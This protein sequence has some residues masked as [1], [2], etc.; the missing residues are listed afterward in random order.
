MFFYLRKQEAGIRAEQIESI[1]RVQLEKAELQ[2]ELTRQDT[3]IAD[4]ELQ[5]DNLRANNR[6]LE[7]QNSI[8]KRQAMLAQVSLESGRHIE[9]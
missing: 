1:R 2:I 8:Y 3:I 7:D 9:N 5:I 4:R 6:T